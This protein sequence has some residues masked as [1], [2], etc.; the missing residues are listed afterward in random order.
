MPALN[1]RAFTDSKTLCLWRSW[2]KSRALAFPSTAPPMRNGSC[3][4]TEQVWGFASTATHDFPLYTYSLWDHLYCLLPWGYAGGESSRATS[5]QSGS[6]HTKPVSLHLLREKTL[7][8]LSLPMRSCSGL[9]CFRERKRNE[10]KK[11]SLRSV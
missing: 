6:L 2:E 10:R 1:P 8:V 5:Y 11:G 4:D 3:Y 9:F 7:C